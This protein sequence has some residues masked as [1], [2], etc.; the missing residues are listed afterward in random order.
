[1]F[2]LNG[3]QTSNPELLMISPQKT[4]VANN[5][6]PRDGL[7]LG[8]FHTLGC[9]STELLLLRRVA[10]MLSVT[11]RNEFQP[12]LEP[13]GHGFRHTRRSA[14]AA[15]QGSSQ[16]HSSGFRRGKVEAGK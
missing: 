1:V 15:T 9:C 4:F 14:V 12:A 16:R 6:V 8:R 2:T 10:E 13:A 11:N 7:L 5:I 3:S